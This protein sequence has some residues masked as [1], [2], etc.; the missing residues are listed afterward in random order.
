MRFKVKG[1][2]RFIRRAQTLQAQYNQNQKDQNKKI[3]EFVTKAEQDKD[4][5]LDKKL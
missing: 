4:T 2:F 5:F 3:K 1:N